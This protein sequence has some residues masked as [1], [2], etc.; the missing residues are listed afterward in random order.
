MDAGTFFQLLRE[1]M[2]CF[3][4]KE[5]TEKIEGYKVNYIEEL[6][7]YAQIFRKRPNL[8]QMTKDIQSL[9]AP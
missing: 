1:G 8:T 2:D 5:E 6:G 7:K 4:K 9:D 3:V